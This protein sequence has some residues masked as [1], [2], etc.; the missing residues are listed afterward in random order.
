MCHTSRKK[1]NIIGQIEELIEVQ[2]SILVDCFRIVKDIEFLSF[3]GHTEEIKNVLEGDPF[4]VR[5]GNYMWTILIL[6]LNKLY[7]KNENY[8]LE[9]ILNISLNNKKQIRWAK[10]E[11][12]E[13]LGGLLTKL[14]NPAI[15]G[16]VN[17]LNYIRS[18]QS[19]HLDR[20]RNN[21]EVLIHI[22]EAKELL[23][24]AQDIVSET[25]ITL[26]GIQLGLDFEFL[27]LCEMTIKNLAE[28]NKIRG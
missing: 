22:A 18:K 14:R 2:S 19:A 9:K 21:K 5:S 12:M 11:N 24:L 26:K 7:D 8:A 20:N 13:Q 17:N 27:G 15:Q 4:F 6:E 16:I 3:T 10:P 25:S 28:Y 1:L 23:S